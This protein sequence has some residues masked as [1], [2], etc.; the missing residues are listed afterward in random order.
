MPAYAAAIQR[1]PR[2]L[3][4]LEQATR[5]KVTGEHRSGYRDHVILAVA[6]GTGL[7]EHEIAALDVGDVAPRGRPRAA[8]HRAAHVQALE[9]RAR[10]PGGLHP[11]QPLVQARQAGL[12][13]A[14][15]GQSLAAD[16]LFVSRRGLRIAHD[17]RQAIHHDVRP[18]I[19]LRSGAWPTY[20]PCRRGAL[21]F[22]PHSR[23]AIWACHHVQLFG[24][25]HESKDDCCRTSSSRH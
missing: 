3:T 23:P 22:L 18:S 10:D 17:G 20:Q 12:L 5:L 19:T 7:R 11:G 24:A 25:P 16:A 9:H 4:E 15:A 8:S 6:L 14:R 21:V 2:T 1:P 13:E